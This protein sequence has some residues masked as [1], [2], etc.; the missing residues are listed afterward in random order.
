MAKVLVVDDDEVARRLLG[1]KLSA[2]GHDVVS[3]LDANSGLAEAQAGSPDMILLDIGLPDGSAFTVLEQLRAVP[4]LAEV[5]VFVVS[6][7]EAEGN[8]DRALAAGAAAYFEKSHGIGPIVDAVQA[9]LTS[10]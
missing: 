4:A 3:A 5:P 1:S 2:L 10:A 6:A 7:R 9:A 8:Q